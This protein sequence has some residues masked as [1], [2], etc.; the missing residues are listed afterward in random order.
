MSAHKP[1]GL[2]LQAR[3]K[4]TTNNSP[5]RRLSIEHNQI[6]KR[7]IDYLHDRILN[8]PSPY[9]IHFHAVTA[10]ALSI[11]PRK[12]RLCLSHC[13]YDRITL[14][15]SPADRKAI[16]KLLKQNRAMASRR[17]PTGRTR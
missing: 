7:V 14:E 12:V 3:L 5:A 4:S 2:P 16:A 17:L 10:A 1:A 15:V 8:D 6:A 11:D 13:G 9:Q